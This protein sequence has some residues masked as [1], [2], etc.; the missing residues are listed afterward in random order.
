MGHRR[1]PAHERR[2]QREAGQ[3]ECKDAGLALAPTEGVPIDHRRRG[4]PRDA[5]AAGYGGR[6][7]Q[8]LQRG[9]LAA[10]GPGRPAG[11]RQRHDREPLRPAGARLREPDGAAGVRGPCGV[12]ARRRAR[13]RRR[14]EAARY[15][16]ATSPCRPARRSTSPSRWTWDAPR[17]RTHGACGPS[18]RTDSTDRRATTS[19]WSRPRRT[20]SRPSRAPARCASPPNRRTRAS[21]SA[22]AP[23]TST[24]RD[25][26]SRSSRSTERATA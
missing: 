23:P 19:S 16:S 1:L 6:R 13:A 4:A 12:P 24:R 18:R 8:A 3:G 17:A 26:R 10:V 2:P 11:G 14:F 21:A 20:S 5:A 15:S 9:A 7:G 22:S 25:R